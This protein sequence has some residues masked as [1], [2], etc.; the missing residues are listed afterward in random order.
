MVQTLGIEPKTFRLSAECTANCAKSAKQGLYLLV[1]RLGLEPRYP[2]GGGF[3]V[4][5]N[6]HYATDPYENGSVGVF[7]PREV[8]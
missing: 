3:T 1:G 7:H 5:C 6:C 2:E 4:P 8:S